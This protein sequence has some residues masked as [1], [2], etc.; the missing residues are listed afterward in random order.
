MNYSVSPTPQNRYSNV[1]LRPWREKEIGSPLA[2]MISNVN[3][4]KGTYM[5]KF[6][7]IAAITVMLA[8]ASYFVAGQF[9]S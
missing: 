8:A 2:L 3:H 7:S 9:N 6:I 1:I 5:K 4:Q